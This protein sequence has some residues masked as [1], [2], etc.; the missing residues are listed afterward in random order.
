MVHLGASAK[1]PSNEACDAPPN[2]FHAGMYALE[3]GAEPRLP[4]LY[5]PRSSDGSLVTWANNPVGVV[6][7]EARPAELP[8][9][10]SAVRPSATPGSHHWGILVHLLLIGI[11]ALGVGWSFGTTFLALVRRANQTI[12]AAD[13]MAP[14]KVSPI[15][16][17]SGLGSGTAAANVSGPPPSSLPP[18][19]ASAISGGGELAASSGEPTNRVHTAS[20]DMKSSRSIPGPTAGSRGERARSQPQPDTP[21]SVNPNPAHETLTPPAPGF[22]EPSSFR[23]PDK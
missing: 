7:G 21:R 16:L 3:H 10:L 2:I 19:I 18:T 15:P 12:V 11:V 22:R 17:E 23:S 1:P 14:R 4:K 5:E 13:R 9:R 8:S 6:N 20:P